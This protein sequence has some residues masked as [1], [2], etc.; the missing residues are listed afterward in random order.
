M[1]ELPPPSQPTDHAIQGGS[2]ASGSGHAQTSG[3]PVDYAEY[4]QWMT[5]DYTRNPYTTTSPNASSS[6]YRS[7][8]FLSATEFKPVNSTLLHFVITVHNS[9]K[10]IHSNYTASASLQMQKFSLM[11]NKYDKVGY[12]YGEVSGASNQYVFGP[13]GTIITTQPYIRRDIKTAADV[14]YSLTQVGSSHNLALS[15]KPGYAWGQC[16]D[17]GQP[18]STYLNDYY[19]ISPGQDFPDASWDAGYPFKLFGGGYNTSS[20]P[21]FGNNSAGLQQMIAFIEA[22]CANVDVSF[23]GSRFPVPFPTVSDGNSSIQEG[24]RLVRNAYYNTA[25]HDYN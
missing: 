21:G 20:E 8:S 24:D 18:Y 16:D 10:I 15:G 4:T 19:D 6:E 17:I 13:Q 14:P 23:V 3:T 1:P 5:I 25:F 22:N 9:C 7:L 11:A 12:T 2:W